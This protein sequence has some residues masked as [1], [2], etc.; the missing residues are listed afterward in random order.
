MK[1]QASLERL[2]EAITAGDLAAVEALLAAG[3]DPNA[4]LPRY[5]SPLT[6]AAQHGHD[7]ILRACIRRGADVLAKSLEFGDRPLVVAVSHGH[8]QCVQT[9]LGLGAGADRASLDRALMAAAEIGNTALVL[10]LCA[11][12][13]DPYQVQRKGHSPLSRAVGASHFETARAV[14][15][16]LVDPAK[17]RTHLKNALRF[18]IWACSPAGARFVLEQAPDIYDEPDDYTGES[19]LEGAAGRGHAEL[20]RLLLACGPCAL[21]GPSPAPERWDAAGETPLMTAVW[22]GRLDA[23]QVLVDAGASLRARG[24]RFGSTPLM[25]ACT[26]RHSCQGGE[27]A[28][29]LLER[30]AELEARNDS[31]ATPLLLAV[32]GGSRQVL[33]ALLRFEPDLSARDE[34]GRDAFALAAKRGDPAIT[35]LLARQRD[36]RA[37]AE[38]RHVRY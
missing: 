34:K 16:L 4:L 1:P 24:K 26:E 14:L 9:L 38:A 10:R 23:V 37:T 2:A 19:P 28:S 12:G 3:A 21:E 33:E 25:F 31:G 18:F 6:L 5:H 13:A 30:G 32:R 35:T 27:I 17:R 7:A 29:F 22:V 15:A 20:L 11:E 36:R 8:D